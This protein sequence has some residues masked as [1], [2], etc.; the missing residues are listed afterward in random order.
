LTWFDRELKSVFGVDV[1]AIPFDPAKGYEIYESEKA[2]VLLVRLEDLRSRA[3]VA[4]GDFLG[5]GDF[6]LAD[7]NVAEAKGYA[8]VYRRFVASVRLPHD[9]IERM[10]DS[11][12]ARHFY[13]EDELDA[14]RLRWKAASKRSS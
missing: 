3:P 8:D 2:R 10:Y 5:L 1:Y 13:S 6:R 11:R 9:Y 12:Y 7:T 14:F 4:F